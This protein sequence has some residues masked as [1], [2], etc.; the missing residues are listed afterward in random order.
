MNTE[1]TLIPEV[2]DGRDYSVAEIPSAVRSCIVGLSSLQKKVDRAVERSD[3]ARGL[4]QSAASVEL[5]WWKFGDKAE[6]IESLQS[7]VKGQSDAMVDQSDAMKAMFEYQGAISRAICFLVGLGVSSLAANRSV[8]QSL[9]LELEGASQEELSELAKKELKN[10]IEQLKAQQD[11]LAQQEKTRENVRENRMFIAT[12]KEAISRNKESIKK[13][14]ELDAEQ[15]RELARQRGKDD[16]HDQRLSELESRVSSLEK[17][18]GNGTARTS[19]KGGI[20]FLWLCVIVL[21][22]IEIIRCLK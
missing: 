12:N 6:A 19:G 20:V 2:L 1:D 17:Q 4:A 18:A 22:V 7:A 10:A 21:V 16:E 9:K 5:H 13:I 14:N 3:S 15:E 8:Y 11:I